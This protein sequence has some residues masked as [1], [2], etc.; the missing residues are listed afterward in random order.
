MEGYRLNRCWSLPPSLFDIFKKNGV[1]LGIAELD[2]TAEPLPEA[3]IAS[4]LSVVEYQR[5]RQFLDNTASWQFAI[6]R[7]MLRNMVASVTGEQPR[8]VPIELSPSGKPKIHSSLS[9][10]GSISHSDG[11]VAVLL[12]DNRQCGVDI[13]VA[14]SVP[15]ELPLDERFFSIPELNWI[16]AQRCG[17]QAAIRFLRLWTRKEAYLKA[18][19]KGLAGLSAEVGFDRLGFGSA[20]VRD[21]FGSSEYWTLDLGNSKYCLSVCVD[22]QISRVERFRS[23]VGPLNFR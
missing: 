9:L 15:S 7:V 2:K 8:D 21:K 11:Y 5:L 14:R 22:Q 12:A 19:G 17:L 6:G 1:L 10:N 16:R 3:L 18:L 13:E 23:F 4:T 20:N